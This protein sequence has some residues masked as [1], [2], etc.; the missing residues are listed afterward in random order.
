MTNKYFKS[1]F[2]LF[3][4]LFITN[5]EYSQTVGKI[6]SKSE[7]NTLFGTVIESVQMSVD[8][9]KTIIEKTTNVVMFKVS[10]GKLIILGDNRNVLYPGGKTVDP[11]EIFYL[12]SKSK[13]LELL[14]LSSENAI[15]IEKRTNTTTLTLGSYTL[16]EFWICPPYC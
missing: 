4:I 8:Q 1:A 3:C 12:A 16:E 6:Y 15:S 13:V 9:F 7:A 2:L 10:N 5:K 14:G 11:N